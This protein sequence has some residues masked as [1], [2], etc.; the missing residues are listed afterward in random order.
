MTVVLLVVRYVPIVVGVRSH[1]LNIMSS[2]VLFV[3]AAA[4]FPVKM[5]PPVYVGLLPSIRMFTRLTE[6]AVEIN[7]IAYFVFDNILYDVML[8]S[9]HSP[10]VDVVHVCGFMLPCERTVPVGSMLPDVLFMYR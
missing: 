6:L 2:P 9:Y 10:D 3:I 1:I 8:M 7:K 4:V 5:F